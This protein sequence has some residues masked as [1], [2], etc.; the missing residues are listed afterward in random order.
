MTY[1]HSPD[2]INQLADKLENPDLASMN[3]LAWKAAFHLRELQ[4][5]VFELEAHL[6]AVGAGGVGQSIK[7]QIQADAA[8]EP[9]AWR[10][11]PFNYGIGHEG[12]DALTTRKEQCE[13]WERK[14]WK[15]EP[16][17][18][19]PQPTRQPLTDEQ[20]LSI[21]RVAPALDTAEAEWLHVARAVEAAHGITESQP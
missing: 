11:R 19:A 12:V 13:M 7:P 8:Q 18:A 6:Y 4:R 17:Y 9:V 5:R 16:L 2:Q 21:V 20:I 15:V 1:C 3:G 10:V 14:G